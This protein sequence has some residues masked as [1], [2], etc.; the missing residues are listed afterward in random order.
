MITGIVDGATAFALQSGLLTGGG[1]ATLT[2]PQ[3]ASA[4]D[5]L[6]IRL[7]NTPPLCCSSPMGVDNIV[8]AR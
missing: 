8:V 5:A 3:G 6:L 4:I 2:N 7:T 1:F